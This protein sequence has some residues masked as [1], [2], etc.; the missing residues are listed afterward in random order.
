[1]SWYI[2]RPKAGE[3]PN[4]Y[5]NA[6]YDFFALRNIKAGEELTADYSTYSDPMPDWLMK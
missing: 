6:D 5:C 3:R 2:N 1:V 4:V